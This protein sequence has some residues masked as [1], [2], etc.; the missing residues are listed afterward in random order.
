MDKAVMVAG[1]FAIIAIIGIVFFVNNANVGKVVYYPEN[2]IYANDFYTFP[3][4]VK[5]GVAGTMTYL[6]TDAVI[7][8]VCR[9]TIPCYGLSTY[10]CCKHDGSECI[11][12]PKEYRDVGACTNVQRSK[13]VCQEDYVAGLF[14]RYG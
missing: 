4:G 12:P 9:N 10:T 1:I 5:M 7:N 13:C 8:D 2:N 6:Y 11:I 3:T 14:E